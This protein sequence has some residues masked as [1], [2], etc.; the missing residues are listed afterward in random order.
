MIKATKIALEASDATGQNRVR[1]HIPSDSTLGEVVE[2]LVDRMRLSNV[3]TAGRPLSYQARLERQGRHLNA[4]E[5]AGET[6]QENDRVSLHPN[7]DA[8]GNL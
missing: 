8:G 4:S 5:I 1:A 7:I 6:L 2:T 3:D